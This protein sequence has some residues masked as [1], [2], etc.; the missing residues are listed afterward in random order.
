MKDEKKV[1]LVYW[2]T[3]GKKNILCKKPF[4]HFSGNKMRFSLRK[5]IIRRKEG[6]KVNN[7]I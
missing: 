5:I 1:M 3:Q 7:V 2:N 4:T 6:K